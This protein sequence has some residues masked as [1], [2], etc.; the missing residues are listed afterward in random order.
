MSIVE[1]EIFNNYIE[2]KGNT[3]CATPTVSKQS[4]TT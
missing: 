2:Q 4:M 3:L 1:L